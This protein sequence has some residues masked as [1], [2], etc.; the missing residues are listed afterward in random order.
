MATV[1][2]APLAD[3]AAAAVAAT[4]PVRTAAAAT[5]APTAVAFSKHNPAIIRPPQR[6]P[7]PVSRRNPASESTQRNDVLKTCEG[8]GLLSPPEKAAEP[9]GCAAFFL[10]VEGLADSPDYS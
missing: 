1:V 5:V 2:A 3:A 4:V 7:T 6:K 8:L 10:L 9:K